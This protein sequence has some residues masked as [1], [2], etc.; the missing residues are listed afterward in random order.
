MSVDLRRRDVSVAKQ[1]LQGTKVGPAG[2]QM[3]REGVAQDMRADP[4]GG[5]TC[6][7]GERTDD[8]E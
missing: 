6:V 4:I 8:L 2:Q 1:R 3:G 7:G 5:N